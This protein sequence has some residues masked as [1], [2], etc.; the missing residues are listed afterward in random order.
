MSITISCFVLNC[1]LGRWRQRGAQLV[2]T[3]GSIPAAL[4]SVTPLPRVEGESKQ[5][6]PLHTGSPQMVPEHVALPRISGAHFPG[7]ESVPQHSGT[8]DGITPEL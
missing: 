7:A 6:Q 4:G 2:L 1:F 3:A 5:K 8:T